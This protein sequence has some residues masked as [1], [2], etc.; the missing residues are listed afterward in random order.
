MTT[1]VNAMTVDVEDYYQ[2]SA[3]ESIVKKAQWA[4][5]PSRV[6]KNTYACLDL[7]E[8][9]EVKATFFMLGCVAE[10]APDLVREIVK[11]GHE[12][13]SHGYSHVRV[14]HQTQSEF[15]D[16][17]RHTKTI[18]EDLSGIAIT[19]YR[20]AS[21]SICAQTP[22]AYEELSNAGYRYSSSIYPIRHDLYGDPNAPRL[23]F[24]TAN[25]TITEVPVTTARWVGKNWP[26]GGGGYFR[27]LPYWYS[28]AAINAVNSADKAPAVFYFHPWEIDP[29]QPKIPDT[30][31]KTRIRHYS[32]LGKMQTKLEQLVGQF[33]WSRLDNLIDLE[34]STFKS[35]SP[36]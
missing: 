36:S 16:D 22:W 23:P 29:G 26:A 11:Q 10:T 13:A 33:S 7:F 1:M 24:T 35:Q 34:N 3:F 8:R 14:I 21:Y 19:G 2:V 18:L 28:K 31:L 15:R 9:N 32:N 4:T 5:H 17:I 12:I 6:E 27:L 25:G 20:A 30:P